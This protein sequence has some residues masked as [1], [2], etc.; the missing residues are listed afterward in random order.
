MSEKELE[1]I[2]SKVKEAE[3]VLIGLGE[4]VDLTRQIKADELIT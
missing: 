1:H 3:L 2:I 4:E